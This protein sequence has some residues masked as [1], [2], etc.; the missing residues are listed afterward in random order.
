M[1]VKSSWPKANNTVAGLFDIFNIL[2]AYSSQYTSFDPLDYRSIMQAGGCVIMG[3]TIV[4]KLDDPFAISEAMEYNLDKMLFAS[5]YDLSTA[6]EVGC[7]VVGGKELMTNVKGLQ[8]N[9]D[10]AFDVLGEITN[11]ATIRRGIYEDN[12]NS[13]RVYTIIGGLDGPT[14]R[15]EELKTELHSRANVVDIEGP[16]L[17]KRKEDILPLAEYFLAKEADFYNK[18]NK[19]LSSNSEKILLNYLWPGDVRELAKAMKR[20]YELTIGQEIQ[21]DALPFEIIFAGSATYPKDL[22]RE[23][24]QVK[25]SI[26]IKALEL[27]RGCEDSVTR[28]L[29]IKPSR[30]NHLIGKFNISAVK[31]NIRG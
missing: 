5:G 12:I 23:L 9:I 13:L 25:R 4:D 19:T 16:P 6:K 27:F 22:L 7:I 1:A 3:L 15:L 11:Q 26:I 28:I 21:P 29:G 17:Q 8:D 30:L 24:E 10:Y 31:K 20:A 18:P 14:A 2:S